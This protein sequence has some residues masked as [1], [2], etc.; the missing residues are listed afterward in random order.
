MLV[1]FSFKARP[2]KA[3]ELETLLSDPEGGRRV[4]A[5]MGATRNILF[6]QG[7]RMVRILKFPEGTTPVPMAEV[8]RRDADVAAFLARVGRL[9]DPPFDP[10]VPGSLEEFSARTALRLAY[11]VR[12]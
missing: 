4:A 12:P 10:A 9:T 3:E 7:D 1:G 6:W 11:D 5:A 8:A 2:G